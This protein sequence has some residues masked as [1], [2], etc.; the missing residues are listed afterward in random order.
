MTTT[1]TINYFTLPPDGAKPYNVINAP[2]TTIDA[3]GPIDPTARNWKPERRSEVIRQVNGHEA[4]YNLDE[5]GF[6]FIKHVT[7]EKDFPDDEEKLQ[8]YYDEAIE[9]IKE[10]TG[11]SRAVIFDHTIRK[12]RPGEENDNSPQKRHPVPL[13]P[14]DSHHIVG[15]NTE[16]PFPGTEAELDIQWIEGI[17]PG[18]TPWFWIVSDPTKWMYTFTVEFLQATDYPSIISLSYGLPETLQCTYFGKNSDCNGVNYVQYIQI[19]D[20]QFQKMGLIGTSILISSGDSGT[21]V[22]ETGAAAVFT[23]EY[24]GTSPYI[25]AVGATEF[26]GPVFELPSP[27]PACNSTRW[28]CISGGADEQAVSV[29]IS[30]YLSGGGFST[31]S[32]TPT[33]QSAAVTGYFNSGVKLPDD[34][35]WNR[36]GRGSPDVSAIGMNGYVVQNGNGELVSGT[37]MSSPIV[38]GIVAL[39]AADYYAITNS[40]LGFLNPLLYKGQAAGAGLFKDITIG[41]N[42]RTRGCA[43]QD[44]F[45]TA[46]GWDPVTGLGTP[47]YPALK[48]YVQK[49]GEKVV[50]RR[51]A[52]AG[53]M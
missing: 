41:D 18:F 25:T 31:I 6:Q 11:A 1:A 47:M 51:A 49:V 40:T 37:S 39:V 52:A 21:Y 50:A 8:G 48:A 10:H 23:P 17:N 43:T 45:S 38:A 28:E 5:N 7:K 44:G 42:C 36:T 16:V 15:N 12:H 26:G 14:V 29:A 46:K 2:L 9:A 13:A 20:R 33:Y 24:P 34:T 22:S 4:E 32:I 19:V 35:L 3:D 53:S 30:Q 27:P